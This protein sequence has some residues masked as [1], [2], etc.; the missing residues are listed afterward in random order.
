MNCSIKF[1]SIP[2]IEVGTWWQTRY[3][4][5]SKFLADIDCN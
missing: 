5:L 2:G 1:G 4:D 3:V